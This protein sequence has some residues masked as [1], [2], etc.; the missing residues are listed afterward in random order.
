MKK[1][2]KKFS[3]YFFSVLF[4]TVALTA[5]CV[6]AA[7]LID[8]YRVF[9]PVEYD[10]QTSFEPNTRYIKAEFLSGNCRKFDSFILGSSRV[11]GYKTAD[12]DRAFGVHSYNFGVSDDTFTGVL[13]KLKWL[14]SKNCFPKVVLLEVSLDRLQ[15]TDFSKAE[16]LLRHEHPELTGEPK[17]EFYKKYLVSFAAI[18]SIFKKFESDGKKDAHRVIFNFAKG[19][20]IHFWD[21]D[22]EINSCG[23]NMPIP[24]EKIAAFISEFKKIADLIDSE[25]AR[26]VLL[27]NPQP[28]SVQMKYSQESVE[29]LLSSLARHS[30][31]IQRVPLTDNRLYSS[32]NYRDIS[33][34]NDM[35]GREVLREENRVRTIDLLE[36][37]KTLKIKPCSMTGTESVSR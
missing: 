27:W 34:F 9:S 3:V 14:K 6:I 19:D 28:I 5:A 8:P 7:F 23:G 4:T 35:L 25:G 20:T 31:F 29:L 16:D 15:L 10:Y 1:N 18:E 36:E 33:H 2:T 13:Q 22:F 26:S 17:T 37:F 32:A 11:I 30:E 12:I 24:E 21:D